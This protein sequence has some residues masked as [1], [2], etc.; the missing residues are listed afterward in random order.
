MSKKASLGQM[1]ELHNL[2]A[3]SLIAS[4]NSEPDV[5][6]LMAAM[7]FLKDNDI[8]VDVV[9]SKPQQN[10]LQRIEELTAPSNN[11]KQLVGVDILLEQYV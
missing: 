10:L 11:T 3:N 6:T 8:I 1:E 2:V 7:K 5:K 9:E 4:I